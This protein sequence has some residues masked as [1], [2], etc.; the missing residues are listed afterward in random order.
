LHVVVTW[1]GEY[2]EGS[3]ELRQDLKALRYLQGS[4]SSLVCEITDE[5]VCVSGE[6]LCQ[7]DCLAN[8]VDADEGAVVKICQDSDCP[9]LESSR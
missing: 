9:A 5:G 2:S 6:T 1:D 4:V 7:Y 8:E 3:L